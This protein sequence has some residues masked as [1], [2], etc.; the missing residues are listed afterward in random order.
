MFMRLSIFYRLKRINSSINNEYKTHH[1]RNFSMSL[2]YEKDAID[3]ILMK[4]FLFHV[5]PDLLMQYKKECQINAENINQLKNIAAEGGSNKTRTLLFYL[6]THANATNTSSSDNNDN[7]NHEMVMVKPRRVKVAVASLDKIEESIREILETLGVDVPVSSK[8][9]TRNKKSAAFQGTNRTYKG[10]P[11]T[12][13]VE[14]L[15]SLV[16]RADLLQWRHERRLYLAQL[17]DILRDSLGVDNIHFHYSWSSEANMIFIKQLIRIA[18]EEDLETKDR[19]W[20]HLSL[21]LSASTSQLPVDPVEGH[22]FIN[23]SDVELRWSQVFSSVDNDVLVTTAAMSKRM[24]ALRQHSVQYL[25][26]HLRSILKKELDYTD[27][28]ILNFISVTIERGF[29]CSKFQFIKF[30]EQ[31]ESIESENENENSSIKIK[32]KNNHDHNLDLD[33][34]LVPSSLS[35]KT[36][37]RKKATSNKNLPIL[38]TRSW[39]TLLPLSIEIRVEEGHGSK[40]LS[41]GEIRVDCRAN[42]RTIKELVGNSTIEALSLAAV[43]EEQRRNVERATKTLQ[44]RLGVISVEQGVGVDLD[45]M[46]HCLDNMV[47]HLDTHRAKSKLKYLRGMRLRI[48]RYLGLADD[49]QVIIPHDITLPLEMT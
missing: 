48:G 31:F 49:G 46:H 7:G 36:Q 17:V 26:S 5:H 8:N 32:V 9:V 38:A 41:S 16:D 1:L 19:P 24:Q 37:S 11:Y 15:L 22:V 2:P 44:E 39:L 35:T 23:P 29:T 28:S 30:L 45:M 4:K 6:K 18:Q 42:V 12:E 14:F 25:S 27:E 43:K 3:P 13:L 33:L 34:G 21:V 47:T 20:K 40:L 10:I